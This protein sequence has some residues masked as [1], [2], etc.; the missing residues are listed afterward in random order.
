[1]AVGFSPYLGMSRFFIFKCHELL[2]EYERPLYLL[3]ETN[4]RA[5]V[6]YFIGF[7]V[8]FIIRRH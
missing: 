3:R 5:S 8:E 7:E 1:M 4:H 6:F 2:K